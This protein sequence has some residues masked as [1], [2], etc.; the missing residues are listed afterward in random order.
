MTDVFEIT[1]INTESSTGNLVC[2]FKGTITERL[3]ILKRFHI[4]CIY[5]VAKL[6]IYST[7]REVI[8]NGRVILI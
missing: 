6:F 5:K 2:Q 1:P 8:L 3:K 4:K 7:Y